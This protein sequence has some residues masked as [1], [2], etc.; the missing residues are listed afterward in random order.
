M[1]EQ[2]DYE[3]ESQ[4]TFEDALRELRSDD[5]TLPNADLLVGL[6]E[7]SD[8]ELE[9]LQ[10]VWNQLDSTYRRV[11]MQT[12]IDISESN[13]ELNYHAIARANLQAEQAELRRAAIELLWEDESLALMHSLIDMARQ[14]PSVDV[15]AEAAKAL[16]R[17]IL[18]G[19]LGD[20]A[21][22]ETAS[23]Q[24]ALFQ[25]IHNGDE[26]LQ[27]RRFALESI[28]NCSHPNVTKIIKKAYH[29]DEPQMQ[30]S[31]LRAMGRT[32]DSAA[33][34]DDVLRELESNQVEMQYAA[35]QAA[36]E[37]QLEDAIPSLIQL[38]QAGERE[39]Q[40]IAVWAMGEIGGKQVLRVL[41]QAA[42][43][44]EETGD[45]EFLEIIGDAIGNAKLMS[46]ELMILDIPILDDE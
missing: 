24:Q 46:G 2:F 42:A 13:F 31:A 30:M 33:W 29:S 28:A 17:F 12:L 32:C 15:R 41:D 14:D 16:G 40:E 6:S 9:R 1:E 39:G 44:A 27:V 25:I 34:E 26:V 7:L 19:E 45:L 10:P 23:A 22:A 20:L 4:P 8:E 5:E 18:L 38:L 37:L 3:I 35:A 36:G 21:E 11:L 43:I